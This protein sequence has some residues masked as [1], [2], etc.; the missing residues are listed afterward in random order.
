LLSRFSLALS[1]LPLSVVLHR[2]GDKLYQKLSD[3]IKEHLVTVA[4]AIATTSDDV[5]LVRLDDAWKHHQ[6][7][8]SMIRDILMY[9]DR[10][11]NTAESLPTIFDLGLEIFRHNVVKH[12]TI[13]QRLRSM[14]VA[15]VHLE[16]T[17]HL[18]D[19]QLFRN[20]TQMLVDVGIESRQVYIEEFE[21]E[22]LAATRIFYRAEAQAS[23]DVNR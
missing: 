23:I 3:A 19:R 14:L 6:L 2:F 5:F 16:R 22:F 15:M 7:S 21:T 12:S 18:I 8:M 11:Y 13:R 17:G 1:H 20:M 4:A 9:M 10:N